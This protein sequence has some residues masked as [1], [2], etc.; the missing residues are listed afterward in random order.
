MLMG[1]SRVR[2]SPTKG[3]RLRGLPMTAIILVVMGYTW[4]DVVQM[5][6]RGASRLMTMADR[7]QSRHASG[8][9]ETT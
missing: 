4:C 5:Q 9:Q 6:M 8:N 3:Q 1:Q 7:A 2:I